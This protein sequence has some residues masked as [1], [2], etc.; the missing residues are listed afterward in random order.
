M[1]LTIV[2][3]LQN[4]LRNKKIV[5][6]IYFLIIFS[7]KINIKRNIYIFW[8][9]AFW[10]HVCEPRRPRHMRGNVTRNCVTSWVHTCRLILTRACVMLRIT[11][12]LC[13]LGYWMYL[14]FTVSR[15]I[16]IFT[17][18][19]I[20]FFVKYFNA[21]VKN[22]CG[23]YDFVEASKFYTKLIHLVHY[24]NNWG[25]GIINKLLSSATSPYN[26]LF[27]LFFLVYT[28]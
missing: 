12:T 22:V 18:E 26:L 1:C 19:L 10:K 24:W 8:Y 21:F 15:S 4:F 13:F 27:E 3:A 23:S 17:S 28:N 16:T 20:F 6:V 11:Q 25:Y 14:I 7:D 9:H 2:I 5:R